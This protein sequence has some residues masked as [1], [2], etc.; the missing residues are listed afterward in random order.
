[1]QLRKKGTKFTTPL[2]K[3]DKLAKNLKEFWDSCGKSCLDKN[4]PSYIDVVGINA[5][6]G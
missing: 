5:Y 6:C 4:S 1:M 3:T 2:I